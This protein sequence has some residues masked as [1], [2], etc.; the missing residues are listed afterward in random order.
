MFFNSVPQYVQSTLR[1]LENHGFEAYLVGGCVRDLLLG[2]RPHDW[3]IC[4]SARPE[5]TMEIFPKNRP[6][7]I[8]HGTVTVRVHGRDLEVTSF[9]SDG[10]YLDN[11]HP[12]S[13]SFVSDIN[14]DLLRRDFTMNAIACPLEGKLCDPFHGQEDIK[15]KLIRCVGDPCKRFSEDSLR[16][17]RALRFS[18]VLGFEIEDKTKQAIIDCS[19]LSSSLAA[20]RISTELEKTLLSPNPQKAADMVSLSTSSG[21]QKLSR[22]SLAV[23]FTSSVLRKAAR[24]IPLEMRTWSSASG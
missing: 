15:R 6:T 18:A 22:S 3:D 14:Q 7:G 1:R 17:L 21:A 9:R 24:I 4:T 5:N 19:S 20:E 23:I 11:R 10:Q 16:M 2:K 13:V 8:K 12:S